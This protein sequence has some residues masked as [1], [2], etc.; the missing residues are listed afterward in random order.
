MRELPVPAAWAAGTGA[1]LSGSIAVQSAATDNGPE[2]TMAGIET[3][4]AARRYIIKRP[5]LT[6]LLDNAN[7]RILMLVAP[8]GFGKTTLAREWIGDRSHVWYR[9]SPAT[10]DVA[11][12][13]ADLAKVASQVV[14]NVGERAI[15]RMRSVGTAEQDVDIL[16]ELFA[17]DLAEWPDDVW[18]VLDD[19]EF[20][21][22]AAASER[23]IDLIL[24]TAPIRSVITSR[25]RP[26]WASARR[27]LYGDLFE[28]G[29]NELAMNHAEA[30]EVLAHRKDAPTS[31]L[32]TLA[33]GWPAVIGL[34]ALAEDYAPPDDELPETLYEYF[35]E[36]LYQGATEDVRRG[37]CKLALAPSLA[38]GV[39]ELL[40]GAD[41]EHVIGEG[42]R[43]GFLTLRADSAELHPLLRAFLETKIVEAR[44]QFAPDAKPLASHL[45]KCGRWDDA[46][47]VLERFFSEDVYVE[48]LEQGLPTMVRDARLATLTR[49]IDLARTHHLDSPIVDLAEAEIAFTEAK[50]R[51][52]ESL[53]TQ[54]ARR[55]EDC[56]PLRSRAF[57]LAGVSA[58]MDFENERAAVHFENALR[59]ANEKHDRREATWGKLMIS[60]DLDLPD[61]DELH[62]QL[63][64]LGDSS[65]SSNVRLA[66]AK[67]LV[68]IRTGVPLQEVVSTFQSTDRLLERV[69]EPHLVSSYLT[70]QAY[71]LVLMA[72]YSEAVG[73][74]EAC[75]RRAR[76]LRTP[77]VIAYARRTRA[78]AELGL[79]HFGRAKQLLDW[80]DREATDNDDIFLEIEARLLRA[81]LLISQGRSA[82]A[83][84]LLNTPPAR[85]PYEGERAEW[86]A[87]RA[88]AL[89]CTG[90]PRASDL[91]D[92]ASSNGRTIEIQTLV[93]IVRAIVALRAG[94]ETDAAMKAFEVVSRLG[95][96]DPFV[97][98]YRGYPL[99]VK[100]LASEA[101]LLNDLGPILTAAGDW[102]LAKKAGIHLTQPHR[103]ARSALS[104]REEEV[105]G[106]IGQG[107]TNRQIATAL[108]ISEAT[109]K[110]H[111][112]HLL[113]KLNVRT[114]T[115]AALRAVDIQ[116][117]E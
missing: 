60:L 2:S 40:L 16:A 70:C 41:S 62:A 44:A 106:L 9:G 27:L 19:Y 77:F 94:E 55:F 15:A 116:P 35:A 7:A 114:R 71:T 6:R 39:A 105:L 17:E 48:L 14:A 115:E 51:V 42:A 92:E 11:A 97:V 23:F 87:T 50:R 12:L 81:R 31:G 69:T 66:I 80:L 90:D 20:V 46:F 58:R 37:L 86:L 8:A 96:W 43:L 72:R 33:E 21:M 95:M 25:R 117:P 104:R 107:L 110:V 65:T 22:E 5:R 112:R 89:A 59:A 82:E 64:D 76:G 75:E 73:V 78:G 10:A 100:S 29:R 93:P 102:Q 36:E 63:A 98:A 52:A 18:L 3:V 85:F 26:G 57:Y 4:E 28:L 91:L 56:H 13:V 74:A 103:R 24:S 111:V 30:A 113:A 47:A 49:W 34:A 108:Y 53:A 54:A 83:A 45:S 38:P 109:A 1:S 67:F 79:R 84:E 88:L 99:L 68:S 61:I 32:V 101:S